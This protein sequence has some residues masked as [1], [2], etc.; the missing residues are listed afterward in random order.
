MSENIIKCSLMSKDGLKKSIVTIGTGYWKTY[1]PEWKKL[2][3]QGYKH[4]W[5][6]SVCVPNEVWDELQQG[7]NI[8]DGD[9]DATDYVSQNT[10]YEWCFQRRK[11][12]SESIGNGNLPGSVGIFK[13]KSDANK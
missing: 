1:Y 4:T 12:P 5:D 8:V 6:T 10:S 2:H 13:K 11:T 7:V 3:N 9:I